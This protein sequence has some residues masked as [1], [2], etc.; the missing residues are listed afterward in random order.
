MANQV[1]SLSGLMK[2]FNEDSNVISKGEIKYNSGFVLDLRLVDYLITAKVRASM[3]DKSY[4]VS[5]TVSGDGGILSA[6]CQCPRGNWICSHMAAAAIFTNRKG[7]SKTDLPSSW[8]A[9]PKKAAKIDSKAIADFFP[10]P[11]PS[12]RATS[13][14]VTQQDKEFFH[15]KLAEANS[16]CPF[17]W[18]S[19][20]EPG[21]P[22][23]SPEAPCLIEDILNIFFSDKAAFIEKCKVSAEQIAW[24]ALRTVGQR[25]SQ[26]WG[27]FRRLRLTG[28]NFGEV[29]RAY[30]R[31]NA[32][33]TPYPPS[34]FKK[35]KG[36][37]LLGT[38][39]AIMWGQMH[40][41]QAIQEYME[42]TGNMV[43]PA[44]LHLFPCGFLG[45]SPDGIIEC[46]SPQCDPGVLEIKCPWKYRNSTINEI[47]DTE[48]NGKEEKDSFY[49]TKFI[50]MQKNHNYWHQVQAEIVA[51]NVSWAHFVIWTTKDI[52]IV[53]VERDLDWEKVSLPI[54]EHFY[55]NELLPSCYIRED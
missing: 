45:S 42:K 35:L 48:L 13:R 40:E 5:L 30:R 27:K 46:A 22:V 20:P 6:V 38:K 52:G 54:L 49:L 43:K 7:L 47:I 17:Q 25:S 53:R 32:C 23:Q 34:L 44:G 55:I 29:L 51:V 15:R 41:A 12:Y 8:I 18:M 28:S 50:K 21:A 10:H 3:K 36:E 19:G 9:K 4:A 39:D 37:Y 26:L 14:K 24:L 33:N 1:I 16:D 2:F 31:H 11:K